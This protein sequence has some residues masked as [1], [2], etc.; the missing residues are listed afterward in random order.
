MKTLISAR[1]LALVAAIMLAGPV[2]ADPS[3]NQTKQPQQKVEERTVFVTGSL[4]P[5]RIKLRR[6]G[7][8]TFSPIRIIDRSEI[9]GTGR[10][11]TPGA[12][13]NEPA[14]RVLGH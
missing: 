5:R 7:T 13:V 11:T 3:V 8:T 6:I 4:I 2:F 14:V 10:Y 9:D 1:A 12:F